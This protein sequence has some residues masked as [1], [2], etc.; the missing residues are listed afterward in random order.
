MSTAHKTNTNTC[1]ISVA[2]ETLAS[3]AKQSKATRQ[4]PCMTYAPLCPTAP[5]RSSLL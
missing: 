1:N 4:T 2:K 5:P 3:G